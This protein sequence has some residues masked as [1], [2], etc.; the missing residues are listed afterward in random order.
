M[1]LVTVL[2]FEEVQLPDEGVNRLQVL[3]DR[4]VSLP[5]VYSLNHNY[6]ML[7]SLSSLQVTEL[8]SYLVV[9]SLSELLV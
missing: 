6:K 2:V 7:N 3:R 5:V 8:R 1:L 9:L 4:D